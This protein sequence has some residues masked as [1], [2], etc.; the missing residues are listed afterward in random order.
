MVPVT[1]RGLKSTI[2]WLQVQ[3]IIGCHGYLLGY[4]EENVF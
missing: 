1:L 4:K 3:Y 2:S